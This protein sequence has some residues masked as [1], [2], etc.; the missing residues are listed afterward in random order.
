MQRFIAA[1]LWMLSATAVHAAEGMWTFDNAPKAAIQ[2]RLGVDL[3]AAWLQRVQRSIT[4]HETGCTG[5]F[6]SPEGLVLT[7]HH[8]VIECLS[9]LSSPEHDYLADGF[10]AAARSGERRCPS[11]ILSVLFDVE[12]ITPKVNAATRGLADAQAN[13]ARK[14]TLSTLE[15]ECSSRAKSPDGKALACESVTLYQGGQYFLYKYLRF[16]DVRLVFAPHDA[17][18]AFGGDPDN[19]NFPRWCLDFSVLRVYD[20]GQPARTPNYLQWRTEGPSAGEPVFVAG[21]PGTTSRLLTVA[22]LEFQ[23]DVSLPSILIRSTELRGRLIQWGKSG[24]EQLRISQDL[25]LGIENSLKVYRGLQRA[26]LDEQLLKDKRREERELRQRL[27]RDAKL[28][29]QIGDPWAQIAAAERRY[30]EIYDRYAYLEGGAGFGGELFGYALELVRGAA[31]RNKPNAERLREYADSNLPKVAAE[32]LADVPVYPEFEELRL[33]FSLDK[34][35]ETLGPDDPIVRRLLSAESPDSLATSLIR[36]TRLG[37]ANV[38]RGLWE[39]PQTL[40]ASSDPLIV[41]AR[42]IDADA[43]AVR[44]VFEDEVQAPIASAQEKIAR[45]RFAVLGTGTYPDA[46]FTLRLS[47]GAVQS[48]REKGAEVPTFTRLGRL[49]ERATGKAPFALPQVWLDARGKLDP[50]LPFNYVT[51]ND[52]VGG[53]SGSPLVD[54]TGRLVG[55]AFDGNIH[56]IAGDFGY[57]GKL[58]RTVAVHP[59]M[60]IT[61]LREV[62]GAMGLAEEILRNAPSGQ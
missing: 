40:A 62:Y 20:N 56:S 55:L 18:A 16:E 35:R 27:A 47:Y 32:L 8:C 10:T 6:I 28:L 41:L 14:R 21:H 5:S 54:A 2:Q 38:R 58:N 22:E 24:R 19:F 15:A 7:N 61:A 48:W 12:N 59:R 26:L 1:L 49:Y 39:N 43:R 13:E 25:L 11:E 37:D 36:G 57:D 44:K 31:E 4:R 60:I 42:D 30:R 50:E 34:L 9:K 51:T 46:T 33:S 53:N 17:I 52:I 3:N 45:A 23:R 29:A